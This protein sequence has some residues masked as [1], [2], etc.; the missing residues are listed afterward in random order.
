MLKISKRR[1][2]AII[3]NPE[4]LLDVL[5]SFVKNSHISIRTAEK[6]QVDQKSMCKI[7]KQNKFHPYKIQLVQEINEND[8]DRRL[9][10]CELMMEE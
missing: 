2:S 6:H 3:M 5:Q 1:R 7:L 9:E 8:S 4:K 10:F